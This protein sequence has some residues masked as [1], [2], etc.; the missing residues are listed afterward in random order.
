MDQSLGLVTGPQCLC[1]GI[2]YQIRLIDD[3]MRRPSI[4]REKHIDDECHMVEAAPGRDM[5]DIRHAE[6]VGHSVWNANNPN[7]FVALVLISD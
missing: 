3:A 2:Q 7:A 5:G 1:Q 6:L 4:R